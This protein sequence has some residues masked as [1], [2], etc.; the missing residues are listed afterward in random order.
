MRAKEHSGRHVLAPQLEW[1][2]EDR[3]GEALS[4]EMSSNGEAVW[5][6]ADDRD[7]EGLART[8]ACDWRRGER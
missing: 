1:S 4:G 5:A 7:I 6:G 3:D 8:G 2:S